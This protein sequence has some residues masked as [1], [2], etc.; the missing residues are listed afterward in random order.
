MVGN[1][2][3]TLEDIKKVYVDLLNN[4]ISR[5]N[6]S[7]WAIKMNDL[8]NDDQLEFFPYEASKLY[9]SLFFLISVDVEISSGHFLYAPTDIEREFKNLFSNQLSTYETIEKIIVRDW[10]PLNISND[11]DIFEKYQ[12]YFGEIY[13]L[14][15]KHKSKEE[16]SDYLFKILTQDM[17]LKGDR[18]VTDKLAQRLLDLTH[19]YFH[20]II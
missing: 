19:D 15:L 3:L 4:S 2:K 20:Q 16:I 6:A 1:V 8:D 11:L 9:E 17:R 18:T 14:L 13:D 10:N 12:P 7:D 5:R